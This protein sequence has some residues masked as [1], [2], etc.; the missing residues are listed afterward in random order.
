MRVPKCKNVHLSGLA[1]S[2][3]LLHRVH[4]YKIWAAE[5]NVFRYVRIYFYA[6]IPLLHE[7]VCFVVVL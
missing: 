5:L 1:C 3:V 4:Y 2:H 6:L 7:S